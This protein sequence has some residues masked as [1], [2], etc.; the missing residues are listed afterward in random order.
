[1]PLLCTVNPAIT[2]DS[3]YEITAAK[4]RRVHLVNDDPIHLETSYYS[5]TKFPY[6][7]QYIEESSSI[8]SIIKDRYLTK[9]VKNHKTLNVVYP[10]VEQAKLLQLTQD[11][12]LYEIEKLAYDEKGEVIHFAKSYLPTDK[13]SFT[14]TT[15]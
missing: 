1:M 4:I 11:N 6:L 15:E 8:Y 5:L 12:I 9:A 3:L 14:I 7:D 10:T 13:V 2:D